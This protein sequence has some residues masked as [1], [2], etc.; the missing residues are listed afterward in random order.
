M[1]WAVQGCYEWQENGLN[2]PDSIKLATDG[3]RAEMDIIGEFID[4]ICETGAD[5]K[6]PLGDLYSKYQV[7]SDQACQ[8][9]LGKKEFGNLMRQKG[10]AQKKSGPTRYWTGI[11]IKEA[12]KL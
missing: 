11:L 4:D 8:D 5:K 2:P 12:E 6:V 10:Y 1:A 7:W 3:Y 9:A